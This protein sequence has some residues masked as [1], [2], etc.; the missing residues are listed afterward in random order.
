MQLETDLGENSYVSVAS[1]KIF[2]LPN[3]SGKILLF[4][5]E[6]ALNFFFHVCA[7]FLLPPRFLFAVL[8]LKCFAMNLNFL[9][10]LFQLECLSRFCPKAERKFFPILFD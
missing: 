5:M 7:E 9:L 2:L 4:P 6:K 1:S 10:K 3:S 8:M